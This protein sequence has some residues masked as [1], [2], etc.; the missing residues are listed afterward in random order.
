MDVDREEMEYVEGGA[1]SVDA[2]TK[3]IN[4]GVTAILG[5]IGIGF[6]VSGILWFIKNSVNGLV[7]AGL[8][9][10]ICSTLAALGFTVGSSL[11]S[12]LSSVNPNWSIGYALANYLDSKD[13]KPYNGIIW[14]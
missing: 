6:G 5:V 1:I 11:Y 3:Y 2:A 8:T 9:R 14:G 10:A 12:V 13:S 4:I 7:V